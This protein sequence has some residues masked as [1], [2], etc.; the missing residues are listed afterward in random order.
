MTS[1]NLTSHGAKRLRKRK[2]VSKGNLEADFAAALEHGLRRKD[3]KGR[4]RKLTKTM[5]EQ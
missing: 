1:D 5:A 3:M 4:M 2:R